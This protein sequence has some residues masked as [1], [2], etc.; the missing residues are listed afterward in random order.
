MVAARSEVDVGGVHAG[1]EAA[2]EDGA[3]RQASRARQRAAH[4]PRGGAEVLAECVHL[5]GVL[6]VRQRRRRPGRQRGVAPRASSPRARRSRRLLPPP[7]RFFLRPWVW[8]DLIVAQDGHHVWCLGGLR[9]RAHHD[10]HHHL[11]P[12]D[13]AAH[14]GEQ[15]RPLVRKARPQPLDHGRLHKLRADGDQLELLRLPELGRHGA[16]KVHNAG[17]GGR[18]HRERL[19]GEDAAG[20]REREDDAARGHAARSEGGAVD[21]GGEVD[22]QHLLPLG[23]VRLQDRLHARLADAGAEDHHRRLPPASAVRRKGALLGRHISHVQPRRV[24]LAAGC[25]DRRRHALSRRLVQV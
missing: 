3:A 13:F 4:Q 9:H 23:G 24:S 20:G 15:G 18:V 1:V 12:D 2:D 17:L 19:H 8:R 16:Y 6:A 10:L 14:L 25:P 5:Q 11:G 22:V 7:I 21:D